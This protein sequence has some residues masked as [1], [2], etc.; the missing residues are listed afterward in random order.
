MNKEKEFLE[1]YEK[2]CQKYDMCLG[3]CGCCGSPFLTVG[4]K[5]CGPGDIHYNKRLKKVFI[6]GSGS[7]HEEFNDTTIKTQTE[8]YIVEPYEREKTIKE[9]YK[10]NKK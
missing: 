4:D 9:Y 6:G 8:W 5:E 1:E 7:I 10:E 3:G 2:L